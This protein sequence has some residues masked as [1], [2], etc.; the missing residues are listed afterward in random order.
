MNAAK[1]I[2][3]AKKET[4]TKRLEWI[5]ARL[6]EGR[7]VYYCVGATTIKMTKRTLGLLAVRGDSLYIRWGKRWDCI[8]YHCGVRAV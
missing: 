3:D 5:T 4:M 2:N 7:T 8:D 1:P 6:T